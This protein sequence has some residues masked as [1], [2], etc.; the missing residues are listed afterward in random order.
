VCNCHVA[1]IFAPIFGAAQPRRKSLP[2][3]GGGLSFRTLPTFDANLSIDRQHAGA[4]TPQHGIEFAL[5]CRVSPGQA[6][7]DRSATPFTSDRAKDLSS[8]SDPQWRHLV[9]Q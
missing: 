5:V 8:A 7:R 3:T 9:R 4:I 2:Q 6:V 1:V